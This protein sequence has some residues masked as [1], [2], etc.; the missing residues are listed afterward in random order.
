[1][2]V[3]GNG[4]GDLGGQRRRGETVLQYPTEEGTERKGTCG[5]GSSMASMHT[6]VM[7]KDRQCSACRVYTIVCL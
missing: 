2:R 7:G 6:R 1:M 4:G 5:K 3:H